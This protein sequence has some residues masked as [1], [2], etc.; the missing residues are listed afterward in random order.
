VT[1]ESNAGEIDLL[2]MQ[3]ALAREP[4]PTYQGLLLGSPVLRVDGIGVI[5]SA[6][7][8]VEH[9]LRNPELFSSNF[10]SGIGDLKN[11]RPLIPLQT[12]PPDHRKY[13][14]IL[15]PLFSPQRM[16]LLE[17]QIARL[18][19]E[20]IDE[21]ADAR[22]IDFA[23]QFSVPFPS[24]VFVTMLGLPVDELPQFLAMK[25]GIIRPDHCTGEPRGH[26][27]TDAHQQATA[28]AVYVYFEK[29]LAGRPDAPGDDLIGQFLA[30]E[31]DGE[32]LSTDEIVDICFLFLIAGLDTVSASL[33]CFFGYLGRNASARR[34]IVEHLDA[35]P[36]AIEELLRWETPVMAVERVATSDTELAGCPVVAGESVI[37]FIGAAN[38]DENELPDAGAVRIDRSVNR[39][40]AFG[41][42]IHR[43]LG[44]HLARLEL[45]VALREWHRRI[46]EYQ[47][48]PGAELEY[49]AGIRS[50]AS[51]PMLLGRAAVNL[52]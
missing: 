23:Q 13:R 8:Q 34:E 3:S 44:S 42:G 10:S 28:D 50:V 21:F 29:L 19:N 9:V 6:R 32:R 17:P 15:D 12:D 51:F 24:Q 39:H 48:T 43:C 7:A 1:D 16:K 33:D 41:G 27:K 25:D 5:A 37:A 18:V 52:R 47:L 26:P 20:L 22:E 49:T 38:L 2:A 46:P 14:K 31:V 40:L 45:R 30:A 35:I 11:R 4:Q 36:D